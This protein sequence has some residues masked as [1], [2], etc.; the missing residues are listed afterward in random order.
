[1]RFRP[2]KILLPAAAATTARRSWPNT[3][4]AEA[5]APQKEAPQRGMDLRVWT[6]RVRKGPCYIRQVLSK[7]G[8]P[9]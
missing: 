6:L 1:M 8:H 4:V 2:S 9:I 7:L 3:W 5:T